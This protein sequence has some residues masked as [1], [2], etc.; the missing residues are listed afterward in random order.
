MNSI[1]IIAHAPLA[2]ALKQ[3]ALH[4]FPHAGARIAV[5]D[6]PA[7]QAPEVT[8]QA[9]QHLL[10]QQA[11]SSGED[12]ITGTLVLSDVVGATPCNVAQKLVD[13]VRI[14]CVA[15]AS[16]PMLLRAVTYCELS[17]SDMAQKA[18]AGGSQG[19]VQLAQV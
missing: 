2:S 6:V 7:S 12:A 14:Q 8:L 16:L 5:L 17:L 13:S 10:L 11:Q 15:G 4:V 3:A 9:C 19:V 18:L 1:L